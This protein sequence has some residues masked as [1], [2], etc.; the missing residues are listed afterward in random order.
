LILS[1]IFL[2]TAPIQIMSTKEGLLLSM[3]PSKKVILY[4]L[5]LLVGYSYMHCTVT[6]TFMAM[7][8]LWVKT[9]RRD[10]NC[11]R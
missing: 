4:A 1:G 3:R 8:I 11:G 6:I 2:I 9:E 7:S 5:S 10:C